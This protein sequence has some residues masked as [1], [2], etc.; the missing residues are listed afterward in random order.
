MENT[1]QVIIVFLVIATFVFF[2]WVLPIWLGLKWAKIKNVSKLWMLFGFHPVAGWITFLIIRYG[3]DPKKQCEQCKEHI[4]LE[5]R[6]CRYWGNQIS[7]QDLK[8]AITAYQNR[9]N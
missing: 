8:L 2:L 7:E 3:I 1:F 4:K 9:K 6:I 5:A